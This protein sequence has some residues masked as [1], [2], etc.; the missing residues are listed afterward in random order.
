M[1][2]KVSTLTIAVMLSVASH[3]EGLQPFVSDGCSAFP[4]G[5][6]SQNALWL[7]CCRQHDQDYWQGGTYQ[8]RL[9]SDKTLESCVASVGEPE[10]AKLMLL[11]VRV[12]GTPYLLTQFRWGYGWPYPR[13]YGALTEAEL[14]Q[15]ELKHA[16]Q[17]QVKALGNK[18]LDL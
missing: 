12:G 3:A 2:S 9:A 17:M 10:I 5:T 7:S 15:V 4:D 13:L 1:I 16:E 11:G 18:A 8:Q 6:L 14:M